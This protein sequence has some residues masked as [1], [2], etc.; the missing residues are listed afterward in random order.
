MISQREEKERQIKNAVDKELKR[1]HFNW[2]PMEAASDEAALAYAL[3]RLDG[4]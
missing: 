2:K 3:A 1:S 4:D